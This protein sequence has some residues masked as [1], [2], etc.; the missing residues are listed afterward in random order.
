[1]Q[2]TL[3]CH[4]KI[5]RFP[6]FFHGFSMV[7]PSK[8]H[9]IPWAKPRETPQVFGTELAS[10]EDAAVWSQEKR[11][12]P[13]DAEIDPWGHRE[14]RRHLAV[15]WERSLGD[16]EVWGHFMAFHTFK[17]GD[18]IHISSTFHPQMWLFLFFLE[19][20][21][22]F[23]KKSMGKMFTEKPRNMEYQNGSYWRIVLTMTHCYFIRDF[24]NNSWNMYDWSLDI[25][26]LKNL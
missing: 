23:I 13:P 11:H 10:A 5:N 24:T 20:Y 9:G 17:I 6:R 25:N 4:R 8:S 16:W 21:G 14:L 22:V 2:E 15:P 18:F 1:M 26:C 12:A 7:F 19:K 3:I